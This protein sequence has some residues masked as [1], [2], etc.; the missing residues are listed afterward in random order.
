MNRKACDNDFDIENKTSNYFY[1]YIHKI[2]VNI[3]LC[4]KM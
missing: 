1:D 2:I 3:T 4:V